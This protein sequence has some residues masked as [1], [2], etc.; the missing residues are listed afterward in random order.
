MTAQFPAAVVAYTY[1]VDL[2]DIVLAAD[3][4]AVYDEVTAL[5]NILGTLPATNLG[6]QNGS[7]DQTTLSWNTMRDRIQNLEYGLYTAYNNRVASKG[8]TT[9]TPTDNST[10]NLTLQ[11]KAGQTLD[12]LQL[13]TSSGNLVT[14]V[15][16]SGVLYYNGGVVATVANTETLTNKTINGSSNTFSNIPATAVIATGTTNIKAYVDANPLLF[17]Q[18]TQPNQVTQNVPVGSIWVDSSS[19][20]TPF[21][22]TAYLL[23]GTADSTYLGITTAATT[24]ATNA[25]LTGSYYNKTYVDQNFYTVSQVDQ[26]QV[27]KTYGDARYL[28]IAAASTA[29]NGGFGYRRVNVSTVAPT[30]SDGADGDIWIQYI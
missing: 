27:S 13:K 12:M 29:S 14:K 10:V 18:S 8:G 16:S 5:E 4:N 30:S 22:P 17:F 3:I 26:Y 25:T 7:F 6:W 19:S 21:D 24:Y 9:I 15:D 11:A 1:K 23:K 20:I 2:R 28:Q